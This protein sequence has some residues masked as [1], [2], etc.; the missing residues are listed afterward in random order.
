MHFLT[1]GPVWCEDILK[2]FCLLVEKHKHL[3]NNK[4]TKAKN[5]WDII[6]NGLSLVSIFHIFPN[7]FHGVNIWI[8]ATIM[9]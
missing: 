4:T 1:D 2:K 3:Q 7:Q 6:S 9:K 8:I 5:V